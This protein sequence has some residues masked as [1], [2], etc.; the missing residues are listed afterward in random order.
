MQAKSEELIYDWFPGMS[1]CPAAF[2]GTAQ[3]D[4]GHRARHAI[5]HLSVHT[6]DRR[7]TRLC[8]A[9]RRVV[10]GEQQSVRRLRARTRSNFFRSA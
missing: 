5:K 6:R 2:G 3:G 10:R 9:R 8:T 1:T 7:A 4:A